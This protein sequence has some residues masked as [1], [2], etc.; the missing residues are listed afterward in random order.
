[1]GYMIIEDVEQMMAARLYQNPSQFLV[2]HQQQK[3]LQ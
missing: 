2:N 1:M 3:H